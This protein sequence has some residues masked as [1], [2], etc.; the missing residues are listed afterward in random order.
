MTIPCYQMRR[1]AITGICKGAPG[2]ECAERSEVLV[3]AFDPNG[4]RVFLLEACLPC[5]DV[6]QARYT[7]QGAA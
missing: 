1:H 5:A 7:A 6:W 2:I 3:E 4:D